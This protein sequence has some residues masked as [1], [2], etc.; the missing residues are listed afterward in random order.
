MSNKTQLLD[1]EIVEDRGEWELLL[2]KLETSN[3]YMKWSWGEYKK[4]SGWDIKHLQF[5]NAKSKQ[6]LACCQLQSKSKFFIN[7]F[8]IQGG[9]HFSRGNNIKDVYDFM[10]RA[11]YTYIK[12]N[13]KWLWML[14]INYQSHNFD[15]AETSLLKVGFV[16]ILT[17]TMFTYLIFNKTITQDRLSLSNN[18]RHNLKRANKNDDLEIEWV[19][20]YEDREKVYSHLSEM[21]EKLRERK[22]F[23]A[24]ID[25]NLA[26]NLM[27]LDQSIIIVQARLSGKVVAIRVASVCND[28][29]LD[30][31]AASN[32]GAKKCYANYLLMWEMIMKMKELNKIYFD[33][34][35]IDPASNIGV[36]NFKKG[37]N[38]R[39][40]INGPL[41]CIGSNPLVELATRMYFLWK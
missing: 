16:P 37:L 11:L 6:L 14:L 35:G 9:I 1:I 34:G 23:K 3:T 30:L 13:N 18:W 28:H 12:K 39:L 27:A 29:L 32:E 36:F 4:K 10:H 17:K 40:T 15:D 26:H 24:G 38:G 25:L 5:V 2:D 8:L 22:N 21:Y 7:I 19:S 33:T 31:F 41:W 20:S